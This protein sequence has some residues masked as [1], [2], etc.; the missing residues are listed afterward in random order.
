MSVASGGEIPGVDPD[1]GSVNFAGGLPGGT[2][3]V[4]VVPGPITTMMEYATAMSNFVAIGASTLTSGDAAT[5]V[6]TSAT[7]GEFNPSGTYTVI[8]AG[9][10]DPNDLSSIVSKYQNNVSF[11]GGNATIDIST[12][13]DQTSLPY[14]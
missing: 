10:T 11:S 5:L 1:A 12:M 3:A 8:F 9:Y 7:A 6:T 13:S 14:M 2:W 4:Y